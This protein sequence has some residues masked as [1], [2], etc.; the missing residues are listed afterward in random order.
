[1]AQVQRRNIEMM[2]ALYTWNHG[3]ND[4]PSFPEELRKTALEKIVDGLANLDQIDAE[5][6]KLL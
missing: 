5:L 2:E 4:E 3:K 1:M 6:K